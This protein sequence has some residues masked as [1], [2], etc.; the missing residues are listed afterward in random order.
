MKQLLKLQ[1]VQKL[2]KVSQQKI[3]GGKGVAL[4]NGCAVNKGCYVASECIS[5]AANCVMKCITGTGL[6]P[7]ICVG[8][9][10]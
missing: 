5:F 4:V 8:Y 2:D 3:A 6:E 7:G 10:A 9:V 1:G